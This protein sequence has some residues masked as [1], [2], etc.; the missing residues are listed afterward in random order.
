MVYLK[1]VIKT[2]LTSNYR[3]YVRK[4]KIIKRT[5][6]E[7][8]NTFWPNW[9]QFTMRLFAD[10]R[11]YFTNLLSSDKCATWRKFH[12]SSLSQRN[13]SLKCNNNNNNKKR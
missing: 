1:K 4:K 10:P 12:F 8:S 6:S 3:T 5:C 7:M 9:K 2:K 13:L 11:Q